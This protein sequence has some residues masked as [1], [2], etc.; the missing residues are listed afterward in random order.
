MT[1]SR[2]AAGLKAAAGV[3]APRLIGLSADPAVVVMS[4]LGSGLNVADALLGSET[5]LGRDQILAWAQAIGELQSHGGPAGRL[6]R[7]ART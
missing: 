7:G 6:S 1:W 5:G 2:E 4:D 3:R